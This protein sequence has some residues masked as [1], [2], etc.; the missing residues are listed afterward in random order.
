MAVI[1]TGNDQVFGRWAVNRI[2]VLQDV[3]ELGNFVAVGILSE[4][5]LDGELYGVVMYHDWNPRFK[6]CQMSVAARSPRW[7]TRSNFRTLLGIAFNQYK[8]DK[9]WVAVPHKN[10]RVIRLAEK[11]GFVKEATLKH[12][13][14]VGLHAVV[15]R[16]FKWDFLKIYWPREESEAA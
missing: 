5:S 15:L 4:N 12:H 1:V 6:T 10:E 9:V 2:D 11:I 8:C 3:R 7:A 16:M 13:L 14:G